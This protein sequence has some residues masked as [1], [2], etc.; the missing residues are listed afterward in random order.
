MIQ[1]NDWVIDFENHTV[2]MLGRT[3]DFWWED[4]RPG[5]VLALIK[6]VYR[7]GYL[8]GVDNTKKANRPGWLMNKAR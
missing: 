4:M 7:A 1:D 8:H 2:E 5:E 3:F 6:D